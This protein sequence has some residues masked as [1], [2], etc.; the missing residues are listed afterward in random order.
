M[1]LVGRPQT[2]RQVDKFKMVK[3]QMDRRANSD[4]RETGLIGVA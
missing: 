1:I 4:L 3:R 2:Y